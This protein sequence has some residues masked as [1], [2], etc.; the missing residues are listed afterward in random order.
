MTSLPDDF[1]ANYDAEIAAFWQQQ[2]TG[3]SSGAQL[4]DVCTGNGAV[5][6]LLA[7]ACRQADLD[8]RITAID[9]AAI[10]PDLIAQ[11]FPD[12]AELIRSIRFVGG[13]RFET[14]AMS[15]GSLDLIASQYGIEYCDPEPAAAKCAELLRPG[16]RLALVCHAPDSAMI[17]AM[18]TELDGYLELAESGLTESFR[19]RCRGSLPGPAFRARLAEIDAALRR[20]ELADAPLIRYALA[21]IERARQLPDARFDHERQAA[22]QAV[23]QLEHGRERLRQ[24]LEVNRRLRDPEAW[25]GVFVDA[26]L[27]LLDRG[28]LRRNARARRAFCIDFGPAGPKAQA[29]V[30]V[31][32]LVQNGLVRSPIAFLV[33]LAEDGVGLAGFQVQ[34][35]FVVA[36]DIGALGATEI[37]SRRIGDEHPHLDR[38]PAG[39]E[40]DVV[41]IAGDVAAVDLDELHVV[42]IAA[43][44]AQASGDQGR[45]GPGT[46]KGHQL[47]CGRR[48]RK[49]HQQGDAEQD[50]SDGGLHG[51]SPQVQ[52][53]SKRCS[54][55]VR[56][57]TIE[58]DGMLLKFS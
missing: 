44:L 7:Q 51:R 11:R 23:E 24:M 6:L 55:S 4:L 13:R 31:G 18:R 34:L 35:D 1:Q 17:E 14:L 40:P 50:S 10:R 22:L 21:M 36:V 26:G 29:S 27:R 57:T 41:P 38:V 43:G 48:G 54:F 25:S 3:L 19:E 37:R 15:P 39:L 28:A 45:I 58:F 42:Q 32:H 16:G 20:G 12:L 33:E 30:V 5:A 49:R 52:G 9:A 2:V 56:G 47:R 8:A 53:H 46:G